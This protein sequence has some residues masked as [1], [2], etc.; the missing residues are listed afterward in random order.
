M[1]LVYCDFSICTKSTRQLLPIYY[2]CLILCCW[3]EEI[4][5]GADKA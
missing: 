3:K 2:I 4:N 1:L 5:D